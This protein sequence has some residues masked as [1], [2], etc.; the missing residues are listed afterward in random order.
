MVGFE[1]SFVLD[2]KEKQSVFLVVRASELVGDSTVWCC[3]LVGAWSLQTG[4]ND[5]EP[6]PA[7]EG[8]QDAY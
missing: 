7:A 6:Q 1:S 2:R 5:E 8:S 4:V 3:S